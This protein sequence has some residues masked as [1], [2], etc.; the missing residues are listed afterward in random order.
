[1]AIKA[2]DF[3]LASQ[4]ESHPIRWP[5][6]AVLAWIS[7]WPFFIWGAVLSDA[8]H[9]NEIL[10]TQ[11]LWMPDFM[12]YDNG[13]YAFAAGIWLGGTLAFLFGIAAFGRREK[14]WGLATPP[15]VIGGA[16]AIYATLS[17]IFMHAF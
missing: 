14:L 4:T 6:C 10:P 8:V 13:F 11:Y 17:L 5:F 9:D 12:R 16:L 1:M 7:P 3:G 15:S 2:T